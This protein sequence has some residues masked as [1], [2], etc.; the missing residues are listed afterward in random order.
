MSMVIV[1]VLGLCISAS[2]FF[3]GYADRRWGRSLSFGMC[4]MTGI[5]SFL[6]GQSGVLVMNL[7]NLT[8]YSMLMLEDRLKFVQTT[9]YRVTSMGVAVVAA[10]VTQYAILGRGLWSPGTLALLGGATGLAMALMESFA[11]LKT[12]TLLNVAAWVSY[13]IAVGSYT[14]LIGNA[15][16]LVG[17]IMSIWQRA[18]RTA[19]PHTI[20]ASCLTVPV[21]T[22]SL[23]RVL[24]SE[25]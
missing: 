2:L 18:R 23:R 21:D 13:Y 20:T 9:I 24:H 14:N 5:Q 7:V 1:Q 12:V 3:I 8:Y 19:E 25:Q 6:L 16:V 4:L 17:V 22:G 15:F 10:A 11:L